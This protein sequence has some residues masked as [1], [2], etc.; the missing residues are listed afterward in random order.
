M[1]LGDGSQL[2]G[3]QS[4]FRLEEGA[5]LKNVILGAPA[6]DGVSCQGNCQLL[7]VWWEDVGALHAC[8]C[9]A[10]QAVYT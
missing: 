10:F 5:V 1:L 8:D 2:E 3:Q 9:H 6:G 4:V 7:N